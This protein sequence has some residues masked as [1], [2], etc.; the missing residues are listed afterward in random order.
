MSTNV[1]LNGYVGSKS[2]YATKIKALFDPTCS[3]YIEPFAGGAGVFFSNYN[4]KYKKE[5]INDIDA[6]IAILY[7]TLANEETRQRV[8]D[9]ILDIDK[10]DEKSIAESRF[11]ASK[12]MMM[13]TRT[14]ISL[15]KM[16]PD[17]MVEVAIN[18]YRVYSQSFNCNAGNYSSQK[19]NMKYQYETKRN[20]MNAVDRLSSNV[21]VTCR[22]GIKIIEK[23]MDRTDTQ[24]FIDWP[25]IGIY[26]SSPKLYQKE[27]SNMFRHIT[28]ASSIKDAKAAI[29]MCDYRCKYDNVPTIYDA[30]LGDNWHCY[31]IADTVKKCEVV[32]HGQKKKKASEFVWTNREPTEVAKYRLSLVDYKEKL[33]M[34]EYWQRIYQACMDGTIID[35]KEVAE[36]ESTYRNLYGKNNRSIINN[37]ACI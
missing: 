28:G 34:D 3:N 24:I 35:S 25:Y 11:N 27:M 6:N 8:I 26:R 19:K 5:W 20:L 4:G 17:K 16:Q 13:K 1:L 21:R 22:D 33:T 23:Y 32:E 37:P 36:Y 31:K 12:N 30:I 2:E 29:V 15:K 7:Y 10:N 18:A 9:G 14:E